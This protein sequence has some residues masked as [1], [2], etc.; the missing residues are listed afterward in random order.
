V[1]LP[2]VRAAAA[3]VR[4]DASGEPALVAY[5]VPA[6]ARPVGALDALRR[7]LAPKLPEY[8]LR[9]PWSSSMLYR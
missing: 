9:P 7:E 4:Q 2:G 6:G 3:A 1:A 5:L 8:M